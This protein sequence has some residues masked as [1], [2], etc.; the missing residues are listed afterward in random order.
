MNRFMMKLSFCRGGVGMIDGGRED[1]VNCMLYGDIAFHS[2]VIQV[3]VVSERKVE[4]LRFR[5]KSFVPI[6]S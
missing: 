4:G 5:N 6:S 3:G 1:G 2:E